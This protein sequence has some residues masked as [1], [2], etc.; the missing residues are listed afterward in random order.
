MRGRNDPSASDLGLANPPP[1]VAHRRA[2]LG[3]T[4]MLFSIRL[5]SVS[6]TLKTSLCSGGTAR[7]AQLHPP[8]MFVLLGGADRMPVLATGEQPD[9]AVLQRRDGPRLGRPGGRAACGGAA[10]MCHQEYES[11]CDTLSAHS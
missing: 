10:A 1:T 3:K 6:L 2:R 7:Y 11:I 5:L 8:F 4:V 9:L